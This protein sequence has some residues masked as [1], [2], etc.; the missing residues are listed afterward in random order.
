MECVDVERRMFLW[1]LLLESSQPRVVDSSVSKKESVGTWDELQRVAW[2][3]AQRIEDVGRE[4]DL[5][6]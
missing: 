6:L 5:A 3:Y 1:S 4:S 2:A